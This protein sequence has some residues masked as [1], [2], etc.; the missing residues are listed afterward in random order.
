MGAGESQLH[1]PPDCRNTLPIICHKYLH[2]TI[3]ILWYQYDKGSTQLRI[4]PTISEVSSEPHL[5]VSIFQAAAKVFQ[6]AGFFAS[7]KAQG[8]MLKPRK[9]SKISKGGSAVPFNMSVGVLWLCNPKKISATSILSAN[10]NEAK[11]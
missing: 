4:S 1:K 8:N 3:D 5:V 7:E 9:N 2:F 6:Q 10:H 11:Q